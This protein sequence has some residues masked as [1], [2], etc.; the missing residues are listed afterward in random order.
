LK[1]PVP[2]QPHSFSKLAE[3]LVGDLR[4]I[5]SEDPPRSRKRPTQ[6]LAELVE[7]LLQKH[8]IGREA[9]EHTIREQ[10]PAIVGPANAAYSHP[11]TIERNRLIVLAAHAVV[12]NELFL[13]RAEI[14]ARI[15]KLPGCE[16]VKSLNLR[17][18]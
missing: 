13:H 7:Q 16:G 8:R 9:P 3:N 1:L 5:A 15:R 2:D 12:R 14:V 18:G 11:A 4:G 17:A 10:W 6:P